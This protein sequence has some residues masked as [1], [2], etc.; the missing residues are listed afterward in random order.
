LADWDK[1]KYYCE[2]SELLHPVARTGLTTK[3]PGQKEWN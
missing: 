3:S 2:P 1:N